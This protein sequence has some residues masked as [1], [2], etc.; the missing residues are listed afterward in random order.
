MPRATLRTVNDT[1]AWLGVRET[2]P[3]G[4]L[5][6]VKVLFG[7]NDMHGRKGGDL[8]TFLEKLDTTVSRI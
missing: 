6:N 1:R 3:I 5:G 7:D 2:C 4:G 8:H